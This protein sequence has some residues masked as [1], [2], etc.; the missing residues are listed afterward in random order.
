MVGGLGS[1]GVP[2]LQQVLHPEDRG[3]PGGRRLRCTV[4][5]LVLSSGC[6]V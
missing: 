6:K 2:R 4:D 3:R 5:A 1:G